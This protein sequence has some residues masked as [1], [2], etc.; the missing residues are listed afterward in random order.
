[1][2]KSF[3]QYF[4][5]LYG[6]K[7]LEAERNGDKNDEDH[8]TAI[9]EVPK[10]TESEHVRQRDK[11]PRAVRQVWGSG[12]LRRERTGVVSGKSFLGSFRELVSALPRK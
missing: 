3:D 4:C 5:L 10:P 8:Q 7:R 2:A 1:M 11:K 6:L 9:R 12:W